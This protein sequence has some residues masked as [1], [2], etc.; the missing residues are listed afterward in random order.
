M[1]IIWQTVR[2]ITN[3]ILGVKGLTGT[4]PYFK[5][6]IGTI[7]KQ[8]VASQPVH[9][10]S[11][12]DSFLYCFQNPHLKWKLEQFHGPVKLPVLQE[13]GLGPSCLK[14]GQCHPPDKSFN[15]LDTRVGFVN[16]YLMDNVL[17]IELCY[18]P[19]EPQGLET[20]CKQ[21][22]LICLAWNW[23]KSNCSLFLCYSTLEWDLGEGFT[24]PYTWVQLCTHVF[25][26]YSQ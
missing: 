5:I 11:L 25:C 17:S 6:K 8:F 1:R 15:P 22:T 10:V 16:T 19:F 18:Y 13:K 23:R 2:R 26:V 21:I 9:F 24:W 14:C 7:E 4:K 12:A 3:E 20:L